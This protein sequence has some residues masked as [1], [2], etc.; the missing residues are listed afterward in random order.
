M[1]TK[2]ENNNKTYKTALHYG[3]TKGQDDGT[4]I[5][6]TYTAN[7]GDIVFMW[8]FSNLH[9]PN[10]YKNNQSI[11]LNQISRIG[12]AT[13]FT[14]VFIANKGDVFRIDNQTVGNQCGVVGCG[15]SVLPAK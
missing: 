12:G 2:F 14:G 3:K 8:R 4:S 7:K 9:Q 15:I 11:T 13:A 1:I 10:A 6:Q 5:A